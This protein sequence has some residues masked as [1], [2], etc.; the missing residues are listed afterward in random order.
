M[1]DSSVTPQTGA[2]APLSTGIFKQEDW[3]GCHFFLPGNLPNPGIEPTVPPMS[4]VLAGNFF[5]T[6]PPGDP[7][8]KHESL[9]IPD[10]FLFKS[11][12]LFCKLL[13]YSVFIP[14]VLEIPRVVSNF[15]KG[16]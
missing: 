9:C 10:I 5:T 6:E 15:L 2:P 14:S 13:F 16:T 3:S 7:D 4:P 11:F 1:S 12:Q 8:L